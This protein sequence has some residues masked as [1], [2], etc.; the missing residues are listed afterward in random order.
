[1]QNN[2]NEIES[3]LKY[4][5]NNHDL[6]D[7]AL[8]HASYANENKIKKEFTNQRLEFLGDAVLEL[9]SSDFLYNKYNLLLEGELTKIRAKLVCE[10]QLS[11]IARKLNLFSFLKLGKGENIEHIKNNNSTMCDTLESIIGAIYLDGG[12]EKAKEFIYDNILID[13]YINSSSKDFKSL[14]QEYANKENINLI[15]KVLSE[16]GPDHD[17]KF[18]VELNFNDVAYGKGIGKSKKDAEQIAAKYVYENVL[19]GDKCF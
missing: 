17:K 18:E 8:T 13:E 2:Y 10:E 14:V 4:K 3:S 9:V 6:L 1:M 16:S 15:Y 5:F 19:K 7:L 11:I 12:I